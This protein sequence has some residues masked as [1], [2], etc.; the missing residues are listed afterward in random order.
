MGID[1][2]AI[3]HTLSGEKG[4]EAI[5]Q[6]YGLYRDGKE[7][8]RLF[9]L[10]AAAWEA[11]AKREQC[12]Y[13]L[14]TANEVDTLMQLQAPDW[15]LQLYKDVRYAVQRGDIARFFI[16]Y[17]YGGL[18][19]DLDTFPNLHRFPKV[20]LGICKM[21]ARETKSIRLKPE[22]EIEVVVAEKGNTAILGIL[23]DM[24]V[25][26]AEKGQMK[27]YNDKPCLSLIHI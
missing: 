17:K 20:P 25:A 2:P 4:V 27:Y 8:S 11:Y 23:E 26:M 18:Y 1:T 3:S 19:A 21:L 7:M 22:Y 9:K 24:K 12:E 13:R 16:L 6:I 10:S 15:V 14:W 5:H